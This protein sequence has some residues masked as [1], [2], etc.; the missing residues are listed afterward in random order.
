M[1]EETSLFT[2]IFPDHYSPPSGF[3]FDHRCGSNDPPIMDD[4]RIEEY[5]LD[6]EVLYLAQYDFVPSELI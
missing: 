6:E 1:G 3:C 5:N 2:S 4:P